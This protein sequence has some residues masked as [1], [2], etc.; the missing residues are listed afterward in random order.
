MDPREAEARATGA[1]GRSVDELTVLADLTLADYFRYLARYGGAVREEDGLLLFAGAHPQPNPYRNGAIRLDDT[2]DAAEAMRRADRF[3]A[4]QK[5]GFALWVREHADDGDLNA[6]AAERGLRE[7]ERLPEM[8]ME[9]MP[10]YLP[11]PAGVEI[12]RAADAQ[13]REDYLAVIADAWGIEAMPREVAARV[14]FDPDCL[15]EPQIAAYVAYYEGRPLS[16]SMCVV[17]HGAALGCNGGTLRV[18][19]RSAL[20]DP[21]P[22]SGLPRL[23]PPEEQRGLVDSTLWSALDYSFQ[24][25]GAT[26]SVCQTSALGRPVWESLG[27][28]A[29]SGYTRYFVPPRI[30]AAPPAG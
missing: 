20:R 13:T 2:L 15:A 26:I 17:S 8:V 29:F 25:L 21:A 12:R 30:A 10:E 4:E 9:R 14:F 18:A 11:P 16:A 19:R 1:G 5:R 28:E 3:F 24:E 27:Y 7:L 23:G 6:L 22:D